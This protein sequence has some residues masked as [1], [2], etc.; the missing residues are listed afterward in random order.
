MGDDEKLFNNGNI[1]Q[2]DPDPLTFAVLLQLV[3]I[4][5]AE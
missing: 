3:K 4:I 5:V 1:L 2:I